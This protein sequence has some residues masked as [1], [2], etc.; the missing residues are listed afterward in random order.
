MEMPDSR[1]WTIRHMDIPGSQSD[2]KHHPESKSSNRGK[3]ATACIW[4]FCGIALVGLMSCPFLYRSKATKEKPATPQIQAFE[5][6]LVSTVGMVLVCR[7]GRT[8][9]QEVKTGARLKEGDLIQTD[10]S[11]AASI[12]YPNGTTV[13]IQENTIFTVQNT[14]KGTMEISALP[15][16][17]VPE[18]RASP[19][20][21]NSDSGLE[22]VIPSKAEAGDLLPSIELRRII[23]FGRSLELVGYV[24]AGSKL[25]VN[26]EGVEISGDGSFKHFTNPFPATARK[27][28][29]IM[30]VTDLAGKT[31]TLS[32][33]YDFSSPGGNN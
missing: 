13:F 24:E 8:E 12:R 14:S 5:A 9:W 27:V 22:G 29:L 25:V 3:V 21:V 26:G 7:P 32:T 28:N 1:L 19:D 33:T 6:G 17:A 11:G 20:A 15:R 16:M 4:T 30:K 2:C 10:S 18:S 23:P 31:R